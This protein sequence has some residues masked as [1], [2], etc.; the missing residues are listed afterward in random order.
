[1]VTIKLYKC[2]AERNRVDKS[3]YLNLVDTITGIFRYENS[4]LHMVIEIE[5]EK[6]PD[7]NYIFI[8]E[9]SRYYFVDNVSTI[10]N[11]LW[12][13]SLTVDALMSYKD[14]IYELEAFVDRN[15]FE[16]SPNIIDDKRVIEQGYNIR[17]VSLVNK[18]F[19]RQALGV[20]IMSG[21]GFTTRPDSTS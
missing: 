21:I 13:I 9:F 5:Y 3:S 1:M 17:D 16:Y 11:N 20:Y 6:V 2:S 14:S 4:L 10:N 18:V 12:G 15:E 8:P 7:F 19:S